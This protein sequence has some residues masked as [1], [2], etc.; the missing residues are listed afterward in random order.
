MNPIKIGILSIGSGVGQSV[1]ES[2]LISNIPFISYGLGN[3][4]MAFGAYACDHQR[5]IPGYRDENYLEQLLRLCQEEAIDIIIPGSDDE[6]HLLS[7]HIDRIKSIG[8]TIIV[9]DTR[10]LDIIRDKFQLAKSFNTKT[11]IFVESEDIEQV[12]H[13]I[14]RGETVFPMIAKPKNGFA[15]KGL[16]V[17]LDET[18]LKRVDPSDVLQE[19]LI[20]S[21]SDLNHDRFL[22][23]LK[24]RILPQIAEYSYQVVFDE[25]GTPVHRMVSYNALNNGVPIEIIPKFDDYLW[26]PLH[27]VI[28]HLSELGAKGPVN[29]QGRWTDNGFKAFEINARFTGITG[30]RAQ[31]GFNEVLYCIETCLKLESSTNM[32]IHRHKIGVR[33]TMNRTVSLQHPFTKLIPTYNPS[34][35]K[36]KPLVLL[37][38]A[39]GYLGHALLSLLQNRYDV[40]ALVRDV[41][42]I[43]NLNK[44][45]PSI[46]CITT[47]Q[48]DQVNFGLLDVIIHTAFLRPYG[49]VHENYASS[50]DLSTFLLKMTSNHQ[51][52]Q[53]IFISSA[54]IENKGVE[55][56]YTIAKYSIEKQL[57]IVKANHPY[58]RLHAIRL[59]T[60]FGANPSLKPMDMISK[61]IIKALNGQTIHIHENHIEHRL[62]INEA[63]QMIIDSIKTSFN[64]TTGTF[65]P[66]IK[67]VFS[68]LS[69]ARLIQKIALD[70]YLTTIEV[71]VD[72]NVHEDSLSNEDDL[73]LIDTLVELFEHF[74]SS[75]T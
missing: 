21:T 57:E 68:T 14:E 10:L 11:D 15:S 63:A 55:S 45:Y 51:V 22:K 3:N 17:L 8:T 74:K 58:L 9:S 70:E 44:A 72:E 47:N 26:E 48:M 6:A 7:R 36:E 27:E 54:S 64:D 12:K 1:I 41:T 65:T 35:L 32:Q 52:P 66:S 71:V 18:D 56:M 33:Q 29:I 19:C 37:T 43:S 4:P 5:L 28:Q 40:I 73:E 24:Q 34:I 59:H 23:L 61:M 46:Q 49:E 13:R 30:L 67:H 75:S 50:I 42:E 31:L 69:I 60:L 20:P 2:L 39:N 53:F 38:G 25:R 62:D 16:K